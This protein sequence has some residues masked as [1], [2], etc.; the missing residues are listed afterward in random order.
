MFSLPPYTRH[1]AVVQHSVFFL[2]ASYRKKMAL[3]S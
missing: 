1:F 3:Q 2:G